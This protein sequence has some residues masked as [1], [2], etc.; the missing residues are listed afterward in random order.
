MAD[1]KFCFHFFKD[2]AYKCSICIIN[3]QK[4]IL[5][6]WEEVKG[7]RWRKKRQWKR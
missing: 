5:V 4:R 1:K 7:Y 2:E 3:N 6:P